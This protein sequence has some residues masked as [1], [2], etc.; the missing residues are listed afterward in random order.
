VSTTKSFT[1]AK[2][3][4]NVT[5]TSFN[6]FPSGSRT[7]ALKG[8][9]GEMAFGGIVTSPG[10]FRIVTVELKGAKGGFSPV[11]LS[12]I[13]PTISVKTTTLG[14]NMKPKRG[15]LILPILL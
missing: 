5:L 1:P 12:P 10:G 8:P 9:C 4:I 3:R 13:I 14:N 15:L 2:E 7:S 6:G 11:Q